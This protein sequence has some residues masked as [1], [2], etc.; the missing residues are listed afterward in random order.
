M[1]EQA[2]RWTEYRPED[3]AAFFAAHPECELTP[4][5][6]ARLEP[7]VTQFA[8]AAGFKFDADRQ[9]ELRQSIWAR[10]LECATA[11][12]STDAEGNPVF[13]YLAQHPQ[14][15]V[16]HAAARVRSSVR[17]ELRAK[18]RL[19]PISLSTEISLGGDGDTTELGSLLPAPGETP[20]QQVGLDDLVGRVDARLSPAQ[21]R[22][23]RLIA[24]GLSPAEAGHTIGLARQTVSDHMRAIRRETAAV[25][26]GIPISRPAGREETRAS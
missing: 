10:I 25:M 13:D 17:T 11:Y 21:S 12:R 20:D 16:M 15:I 2:A 6:I 18:E 9:E 4:E 8:R 19:A 7:Y 5:R 3:P 14:Y 1:T 24:N 22:L 23:F 26:E